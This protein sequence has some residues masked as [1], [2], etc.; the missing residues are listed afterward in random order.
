M[1]RTRSI[2][3]KNTKFR[4]RK[5]YKVL[6]Q[7]VLLALTEAVSHSKLSQTNDRSS[8][9]CEVMCSVNIQGKEEEKKQTKKKHLNGK[10]HLYHHNASVHKIL[11]F[12]RSDSAF[13]P[14]L[15]QYA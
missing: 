8:C 3:I 12:L 7:R 6:K 2:Q 4:R 11:I 13:P 14:G 15:K 9:H 1:I 5:H 10:N